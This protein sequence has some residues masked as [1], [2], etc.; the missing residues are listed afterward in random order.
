MKENKLLKRILIFAVVLI[1]ETISIIIIINTNTQHK[2]REGVSALLAHTLKSFEVLPFTLKAEIYLWSTSE[3]YDPRKTP[4]NNKDKWTVC[5]CKEF[6]TKTM[7]A[8]LV[9]WMN[10]SDTAIRQRSYITNH[11]KTHILS[12]TKIINKIVVIMKTMKN[13]K[14][15]DNDQTNNNNNVKVSDIIGKYRDKDRYMNLA[16]WKSV[17]CIINTTHLIQLIRRFWTLSNNCG[18]ICCL[19]S[20]VVCTRWLIGSLR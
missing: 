5:I 11:R 13:K 8:S 20:N 14:L 16:S 2:R 17:P 7:N 19:K 18:Y 10:E 12:Y 3:I 9:E 15:K 6:N 4:R 1:S